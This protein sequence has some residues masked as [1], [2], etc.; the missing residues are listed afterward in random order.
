MFKP[1]RMAPFLF[2][3]LLAACTTIPEG[4]GVTAL[5]GRGK[6]TQQ[7]H[8]DDVYC[9]QMALQQ[10]GG[11]SA[12]DAAV[13]SGVRSA[14]L[15]TLLGAAAGTLIGGQHGTEAGAGAGLVFGALA[16][17]G[18]ADHAAYTTQQRYDVVYAQC[19]YDSGHRVPVS[20]HLVVERSRPIPPPPSN[21]PPPNMPPPPMANPPVSTQR[22]ETLFVYPKNGQSEAQIA[23]DRRK[24]A[25]WAIAQ[26]GFDPAKDRPSDARIGDYKRASAA[27]LE[28][29][30]YSVK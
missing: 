4:P 18:A 14:A 15:G 30:G 1:V 6:A 28:S 3:V 22:I 19:M 10:S 25:A 8:A 11:R 13:D 29:Y 12:N 24:C 26:T 27:C 23:A 2:P 5:P 16:G 17:T 20:S 7:F 21:T 9:R